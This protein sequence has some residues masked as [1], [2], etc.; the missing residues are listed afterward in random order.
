MGFIKRW[1]FKKFMGN[2]PSSNEDMLKISDEYLKRS[3]EEHAKQLKIAQRVNNANLMNA[4]TKQIKEALKEGLSDEDDSDE[5]EEDDE[6]D[7][8]NTADNL[9]NSVVNNLASGFLNKGAIGGAAAPA[10]AAAAVP[11]SEI[12]KQVISMLG[13]MPDEKIAFYYNLLKQKGF[14]Q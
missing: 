4:Q 1:I 14:I 6:D 10:I 11:S 5:Y 8:D 9:L 3:T 12:K 7:S 13:A 2:L